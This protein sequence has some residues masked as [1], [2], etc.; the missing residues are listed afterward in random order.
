[1]KAVQLTQWEKPLQLNDVPVPEPGPGEVL[2]R[3]AAAGLCH[4]DLHLMEWP[5]GL[6]PYD[7]PFTLGH[8]NA[9]YVERVG[10]GVS[11][12]A[13]DEAVLVYGPW[14]CGT[15]WRCSR[16]EENICE[17]V[18][19]RRSHGGGL[20]RDG[21]LAE[22]V[23]VPSERLLVPIGDLDPVLAAPL[24]DAGLTPYH[25]IKRVMPHLLPGSTAAIVGVGGLGHMAVQMLAA[26]TP[27]RIIAVDPRPEARALAEREGAHVALPSGE[28]AAQLVRDETARGEGAS[29]V[30]DFVGNDQTVALA[31]AVAAVGSQVVLVGLGGGQYPMSFGGSP[32]ETSV[33]IPNWGT[34]SEL[35]E[36]VALA[37]SG[38]L[39]VS[40]ERIGLEDVIDTYGRLLRGDV[41]GRAV[42]VP[43]T[44]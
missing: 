22:Y 11:Q 38:V 41:T 28:E 43:A 33:W 5:E 15:C 37:R 25:V 29:V 19:E 36:V 2:L 17:N 6:L 44:A 10:A 23:V 35:I 31:A 18:G 13:R 14:G 12:V 1:M 7:L 21:G 26:L 40:I 9:G 27:A 42:A 8:E 32:L 24:T 30:L 4:S 20:G 16:G 34:R 39:D 3:V